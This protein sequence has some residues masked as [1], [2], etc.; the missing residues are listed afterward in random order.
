MG[1]NKKLKGTPSLNPPQWGNKFNNPPLGGLPLSRRGR[2]LLVFLVILKKG[3]K[4]RIKNE[5]LTASEYEAS[6]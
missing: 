5:I 3:L 6:G 1:F 2:C 4:K